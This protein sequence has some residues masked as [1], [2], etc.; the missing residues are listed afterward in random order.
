MSANLAYVHSVEGRG[1]FYVGKGS[2][3]R[4]NETNRNRRNLHY[5]NIADKYGRDNIS[6]G[7]LECSSELIAFDLEVGLIKCLK[8]QGIKLANKTNGG[9][10]ASGYKM[11]SEEKEALSKRMTGVVF[12]DER[13]AR[14]SKALK[15]NTNGKGKTYTRTDEMRSNISDAQR[16]RFKH[17]PMSQETKDKMSKARIGKTFRKITCPFCQKEGSESGM[18]SWHFNYC[19]NNPNRIERKR[20]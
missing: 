19:K 15:G 18:K 11:T 16:N 2:K 8:R 12:S 14:I 3:K 13:R 5:N 20:G 17:N 6:I 1:I 10:G 9:E 7:S 4:A